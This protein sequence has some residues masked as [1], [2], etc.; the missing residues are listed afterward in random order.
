MFYDRNADLEGAGKAGKSGGGE[1]AEHSAGALLVR[2]GPARPQ[3]AGGRPAAAGGRGG[4]APAQAGSHPG[5]AAGGVCLRSAAGKMGPASGVHFRLAAGHRGGLGP[6][7]PGGA[8]D[9]GGGGQGGC[10]R[11]AA[12]G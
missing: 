1:R 8:G 10:L 2:G 7:V 9:S 6:L 5:S 4:E 12:D 3:N 11:R